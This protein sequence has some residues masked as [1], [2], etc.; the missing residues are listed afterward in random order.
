[1]SRP[2]LRCLE[3]GALCHP[4]RDARGRCERCYQH[5][6]RLRNRLRD[7]YAGHW[8]TIRRALI[9][10]HPWCEVCHATSDLTADHIVPVVAGGTHARSNLQVLCRT[11]NSA[12]GGKS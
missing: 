3:C 9:A 8:P 11:C 4:S 1:M 2:L 7:H 5:K 10:S 12:K 6:T